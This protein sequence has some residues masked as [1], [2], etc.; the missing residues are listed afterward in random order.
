VEMTPLALLVFSDALMLGA[1][2]IMALISRRWQVRCEKVRLDRDL[3]QRLYWDMEKSCRLVVDRILLEAGTVSAEQE[4]A[5]RVCTALA[6]VANRCE[7]FYLSNE[8]D[9]LLKRAMHDAVRSGAST[10]AVNYLYLA[11]ERILEGWDPRKDGTDP[12]RAGLDRQGALM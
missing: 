12:F 10:M 1:F 4:R 5:A 6:L 8:K 7:L 11:R 2:L 3:Y 9:D